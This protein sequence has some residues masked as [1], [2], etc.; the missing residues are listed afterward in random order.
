MMVSASAPHVMTWRRPCAQPLEPPVPT[1]W[2]VGGPRPS[3]RCCYARRRGRGPGQN[4][5]D[6]HNC[7]AHD[8][9]HFRLV[10]IRD[11]DRAAIKACSGATFRKCHTDNHFAGSRKASHQPNCGAPKWPSCRHRRT[12]PA[13]SQSSNPWKLGT[14]RRSRLPQVGPL[15][16]EES[17]IRHIVVL[18]G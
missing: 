11:H 18:P 14:V 8:V 2:L 6:S 15:I 9:L 1:P 7:I 10:S 5:S 16:P 4:L 12:T 17:K 3:H 13:R